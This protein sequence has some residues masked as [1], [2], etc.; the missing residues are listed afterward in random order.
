VVDVS[1]IFPVARTQSDV[2]AYL[3]DFTN[4]TQW[5]PGTIRCTRVDAGPIRVGSTW[6]NVSK[7][8]GRET[9]LDYELVTLEPDRVVLR[10]TNK[11]ATSTD[12]IRVA[13]DGDG[14]L[15]TYHAHVV[16]NGAA[17]L[18]EPLMQRVFEKLG[19]ETVHGITNALQDAPRA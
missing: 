13:A 15:V 3:S 6:K 16:F 18:A 7:V 2:V 12:D 19:D 9:Q 11:T 14:S 17:K 8:L 4:A 10:G 1:R 5:D